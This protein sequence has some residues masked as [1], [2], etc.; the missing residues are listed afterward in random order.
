LKPFG[1]GDL[2]IR[3]VDFNRLFIILM[4]KC[5][6]LLSLPEQDGHPLILSIHYRIRKTIITLEQYYMVLIYNLQE[7]ANEKYFHYVFCWN[8]A[9]SYSRL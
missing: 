4:K 1:D 7:Y 3:L 5:Q 2:V 6:R 8:V 9:F